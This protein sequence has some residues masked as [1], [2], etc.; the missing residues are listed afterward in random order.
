MNAELKATIRREGRT[1]WRTLRLCAA[2]VFLA[3]VMAEGLK[4]WARG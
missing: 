2:A 3:Y 4:L 1:T